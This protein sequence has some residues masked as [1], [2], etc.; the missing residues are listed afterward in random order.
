MI[1]NIISEYSKL[2][3]KENKIRHNRVGKMIHSELCKK[4]KFYHNVRWY[5]HKPESVLNETHKILLHFK[6]QVDHQ[7]SA[8][9]PDL[10]IVN[11]FFKKREKEF[12]ELWTFGLADHK[13]KEKKNTNT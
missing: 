7:I 1:I 8:R 10:V 2:A 11:K 5:M 3:Q 13:V 4:F 6:I 12:S 9:R